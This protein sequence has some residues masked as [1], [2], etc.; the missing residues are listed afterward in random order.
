MSINVIFLEVL[1]PKAPAG[2]VKCKKE[3]PTFHSCKDKHIEEA[4]MDAK[5]NRRRWRNYWRKWSVAGISCVQKPKRDNRGS[6]QRDPH[7]VSCCF[8][9]IHSRKWIKKWMTKKASKRLKRINQSLI[10]LS[11]KW[12]MRSHVAEMETA[13]NQKHFQSWG[14]MTQLKNKAWVKRCRKSL[15]RR[16]SQNSHKHY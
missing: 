6:E 3:F 4:N 15:E 5:P 8:L 11:L 2:S 10:Q 14:Q 9:E 7:Q 1:W 12:M 16:F 13:K